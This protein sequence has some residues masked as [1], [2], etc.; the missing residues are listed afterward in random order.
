[1]FCRQAV[2]RDGKRFGVGACTA[3]GLRACFELRGFA[4]ALTLD[5]FGIGFRTRLRCELGVAI[6]RDSRERLLLQF[7]LGAL[8]GTGGIQR[9]LLGR[10]ARLRRKAGIALC[11]RMRRCSLFCGGDCRGARL[12][13]RAS[14]LLGCFARTRGG[15]GLCFDALARANLFSRARIGFG[16]QGRFLLE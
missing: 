1:M 5:H 7:A 14:L 16:T 6:R 3:F 4:R 9:L 13:L 2:L 11:L 12:C 8:T 15:L 10:C